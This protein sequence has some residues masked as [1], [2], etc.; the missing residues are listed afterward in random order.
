MSAPRNGPYIYV[1][2]LTKV[3]AG[4]D[5][6]LWKAWFK[7]HNKYDKLPGTLDLTKWTIDHNNLMGKRAGELRKE[8]Y[9]VYLES[10]NQFN[11]KGQT[12][13]IVAGKPDIVA[14]K[15]KQVLVVD[16][17]TGKERHSDKIQVM[18]YMLI[19]PHTHPACAGDVEINGEV[20]YKDNRIDIERMDLANF[21]D[22]F[23]KAVLK[24]GGG[25]EL[26]RVPSHQECAWCDIGKIDCSERIDGQTKTVKTEMF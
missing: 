13:I 10:Q 20:C 6:C 11:F 1:T 2:W 24:V 23:K 19:L 7:A 22:D 26:S 16:C 25:T 21:Q 17:K 8:G 3:I 14:V 9:S 18:V 4:E 15:D 5:Q 12:G